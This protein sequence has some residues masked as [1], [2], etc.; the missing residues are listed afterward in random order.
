MEALPFH[1]T[2][3]FSYYGQMAFKHARADLTAQYVRSIFDYDPQTGILTRKKCDLYHPQKVG[4]PAGFRRVDG[5][6]GVKIN[7]REYRA[8]RIIWLIMTGE[9]AETE[10]DHRDRDPSNNR[11]ANLRLA[12]RS[13]NA[14]NQKLFKTNKTGFKGVTVDPKNGRYRACIVFKGKKY[15]LGQFAT[16]EKAHAVR[17]IWAKELYGE[18]AI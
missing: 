2:P 13:Q 14:A 8:H 6:I 15:H 11:W 16:A 18:F 4:K 17:Y 5:G 10:I 3:D 12:T 1:Q 9:W 7:R